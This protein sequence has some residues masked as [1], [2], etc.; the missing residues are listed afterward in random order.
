MKQ[1]PRIVAA[2]SFL[3]CLAVV[4]PA[5]AYVLPFT[6]LA[7]QLQERREQGGAR[8]QVV[9]GTLALHGSHGE[10]IIVAAKR[11]VMAQGLC[12]LDIVDPSASALEDAHVIWDGSRARGSDHS[13]L[14]LVKMMESLACPLSAGGSDARGML[15]DL[16]NRLGVDRRYTGYS[17]LDGRVAYVIGAPPW[18]MDDPALWLDKETLL[19]VRAMGSL[20]GAR[21]DLRMLGYGDLVD[22]DWHPRVIELRVDGRLALTFQA[23]RVERDVEISAALFN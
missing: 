15:Q 10:R 14:S 20:G 3:A 11:T 13:E 17:R 7:H 22:G 9:G 19:P 16:I 1:R 2:I 23:E 12:R 8:S 4:S 6:P 21:V 18:E 5:A